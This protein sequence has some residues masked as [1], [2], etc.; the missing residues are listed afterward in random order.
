M[1][2]ISRGA[3][4]EQ[5]ARCLMHPS[6]NMCNSNG[7]T[8]RLLS[9]RWT[10]W[11]LSWKR[12][13]WCRKILLIIS[14]LHHMDFPQR[15]WKQTTKHKIMCVHQF[16]IALLIADNHT[17]TE[18]DTAHTYPS[19]LWPGRS[20]SHKYWPVHIGP[21]TEVHI[22]HTNLFKWGCTHQLY[23]RSI[24]MNTHRSAFLRTLLN[25]TDSE[26]FQF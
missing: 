19:L 8:N 6:P 3:Q 1:G 18:A 16:E 13:P 4:G 11:I 15:A 7:R 23:P 10:I 14:T 5:R 25:V 20:L 12:V 26:S 22:L 9:N 2:L 24:S 17:T 21:G